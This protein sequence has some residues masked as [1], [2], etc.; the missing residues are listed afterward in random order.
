MADDRFLGFDRP[1][2]G[3]KIFR[4]SHKLDLSLTHWEECEDQPEQITV[5]Y[6][7]EGFFTLDSENNAFIRELLNAFRATERD[8]GGDQ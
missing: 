2:L 7:I 8:P 1:E 4:K 6:K 5:N 3:D